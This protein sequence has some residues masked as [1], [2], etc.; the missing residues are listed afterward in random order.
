MRELCELKNAFG[1]ADDAF[2]QNLRFALAKMQTERKTI[3]MKKRTLGLVIVIA[4]LCM[5][6]AGTT[7]ALSN[8]WG[9]M[10]FL[11]ERSGVEVL[12]EATEI[13]QVDMP[14]TGVE[15]EYAKFM[16]REAIYD[17]QIVY[18]VVDVKPTSPQ[19]LLL[20]GDT[21][22]DVSFRDLGQEKDV[23]IADYARENNMI[24]IDAQVDSDNSGSA[25]YVLQEDGTLVYM[26]EFEYESADTEIELPLRCYTALFSE[27]DGSPRRGMENRQEGVLSV[28]LRNSGNDKEI[29]TGTAVYA[30]CGVR[31]DKVT[32]TAS[33]MAIYA[34]IE[35]TV[36]DAEA[37]A[38][39][40]DS[41]W[42]EF[43]D[44]NG[45]RLPSGAYG[46]GGKVALDE[47]GTRFEI[48]E[49]LQASQTLPSEII[50]RAYCYFDGTRYETHVF[51]MN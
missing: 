19:Y 2:Q 9:M 27:M 37:F 45:E 49:N 31:V 47:S 33:P 6:L 7:L 15:T 30:D 17:G 44:A 42:F 23:I 13:I 22:P 20:G 46:S 5:I 41:L 29:S 16:V 11:R 24:C 26:L 10:D 38:K 43:L 12:P 34:V 1:T 3:F 35:Y 4:L 39:T 32:L 18:I 25:A 28:T 50:L 40:D 21:W 48:H 51:E 36:I 14:Q 8:A